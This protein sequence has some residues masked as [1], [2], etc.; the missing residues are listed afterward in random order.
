MPYPPFSI[1]ETTTYPA[2][3]EEDL[4]A[5]KAAGVDGIGIWEF[6]LPKGEDARSVEALRA[7]GLTA[8]ICVPEVPCIVPDAYFRE[9]RDP[10]ERRKALCASI[11]RFA[12]FNPVGVMVLSGAPGDDPAQDRRTIVEG[13]K[14]A[15]D[16]AGEAGVALGFEVHPQGRRLAHLDPAGD[17]WRP[18]GHRRPQHQDHLRHLALLGPAEH[19]G[20]SA[21][22]TRIDSSAFRS[23]IGASPAAGPIGCFR[24]TATSTCRLFSARWTPAASGAGTISRCS[25]T[26][27]GGATPIRSPSTSSKL[28]TR[29][30]AGSRASERHGTSERRRLRKSKRGRGPGPGLAAARNCTRG[31]GVQFCARAGLFKRLTSFFC[32]SNRIIYISYPLYALRSPWPQDRFARRAIRNETM[33]SGKS[34]HG[35]EPTPARLRRS[36][37]MTPPPEMAIFHVTTSSD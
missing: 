33:S 31:R 30:S 34:V 15:A 1:S 19:R 12:A 14:A 22:N 32:N 35:N 2:T 29:P 5:Y 9:P 36:P 7:S 21:R 3:Y 26:T 16:T 18:R 17:A 28:S 8:T 37:P 13:L 6:K 11:R 10:K 4:A 20:R 25:R 27:A 23:T 24:A